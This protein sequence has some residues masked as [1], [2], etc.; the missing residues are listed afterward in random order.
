MLEKTVLM[1]RHPYHPSLGSTTALAKHT[2]TCDA[3]FYF[4]RVKSK[5]A[6]RKHWGECG[7]ANALDRQ[8]QVAGWRAGSTMAGK[9]SQIKRK[10]STVCMFIQ[11]STLSPFSSRAA[12]L[13]LSLSMHGFYRDLVAITSCVGQEVRALAGARRTV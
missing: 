5:Q 11:R 2:T 7:T 3:H 9:K 4:R 1:P 13:A 8:Q 10:H 6:E 12:P